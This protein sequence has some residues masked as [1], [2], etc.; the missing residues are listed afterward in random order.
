MPGC[1]LRLERGWGVRLPAPFG[2]PASGKRLWVQT[3]E[4]LAKGIGNQL[5]LREANARN[6]SARRTSAHGGQGY[7]AIPQRPRNAT[8]PSDT[9]SRIDFGQGSVAATFA[10]RELQA[11]EI[12]VV[13]LE[14]A[15]P[16]TAPEPLRGLR[17]PLFGDHPCNYAPQQCRVHVTAHFSMISRPRVREYRPV[18]ARRPKAPRANSARRD[19]RAD[20]RLWQG[21]KSRVTSAAV[22]YCYRATWPAS[23]GSQSSEPPASCAGFLRQMAM[24]PCS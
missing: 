24:P 12:P 7:S 16:G 23:W 4:P 9:A 15:R 22:T 8:R 3:V 18:R 2:Y 14:T 11:F 17:R 5:R 10:H 13:A 21:G 20:L 1:A 6:A 19:Q